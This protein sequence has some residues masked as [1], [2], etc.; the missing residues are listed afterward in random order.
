MNS[1]ELE[2]LLDQLEG[3]ENSLFGL[4]EA[5][6]MVIREPEV[7][8]ALVHLKGAVESLAA[9]KDKRQAEALAQLSL[10]SRGAG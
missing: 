4:I 2:R 1:A 5:E 3:A 6:P 10:E 8:Q 9:A 7:Q